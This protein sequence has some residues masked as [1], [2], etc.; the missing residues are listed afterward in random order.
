MASE[1]CPT[2]LF[3][4]CLF[5]CNCILPLLTP[6]VCGSTLFAKRPTLRGGSFNAV[7]LVL[8]LSLYIAR[9]TLED[10]S[11]LGRVPW[12]GLEVLL[13]SASGGPRIRERTRSYCNSSTDNLR[14]VAGPGMAASGEEASSTGKL[15]V[16]ASL[17]T[18]PHLYP[19]L[20]WSLQAIQGILQAHFQARER[21]VFPHPLQVMDAQVLLEKR[22]RLP[23]KAQTP[24]SGHATVKSSMGFSP[25]AMS[26][27]QSLDK[28][29]SMTLRRVLSSGV[30]LLQGG[31]PTRDNLRGGSCKF[32]LCSLSLLLAVIY[33][34]RHSMACTMLFATVSG[35]QSR[36]MRHEVKLV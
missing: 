1:S 23:T 25:A 14:L 29:W 2:R 9:T 19:I 35:K 11:M 24:H 15:L 21:F 5:A 26:V 16:A 12:S 32:P 10:L 27:S 30:K 33:M 4:A 17:E 31:T 8:F 28:A 13:G 6:W 34:R 3:L 22:R 20:Q 18:V 36:N 7:V